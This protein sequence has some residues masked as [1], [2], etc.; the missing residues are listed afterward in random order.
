M[1]DA[2]QVT[3][4]CYLASIGATLSV[5]FTEGRPKHSGQIA[6]PP[7][8]MSGIQIALYLVMGIAWPLTWLVGFLMWW[9][10]Q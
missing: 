8:P 2:E 4:V 7:Y 3:I 9:R 10:R 6:L 5:L 1:T